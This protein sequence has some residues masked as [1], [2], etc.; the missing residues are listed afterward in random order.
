[1]AFLLAKN[2]IFFETWDETLESILSN[3]IQ[4]QFFIKTLKDL[5][6]LEPKKP[7]EIYKEMVNEKDQKINSAV[8]NLADT[9]VSSLVNF[10]SNAEPLFSNKDLAWISKLKD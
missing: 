8:L 5:S 6:L 9:I 10:G 4:N 3:K 2:R 7:S 1:M